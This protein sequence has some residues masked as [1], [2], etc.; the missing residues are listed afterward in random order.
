MLE[1]DLSQWGSIFFYL[2]KNPMD[3]CADIRTFLF[4]FMF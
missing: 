3:L 1:S 4:N 2:N